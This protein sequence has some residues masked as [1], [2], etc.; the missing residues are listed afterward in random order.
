MD[1]LSILRA[2]LDPFATDAQ[3]DAHLVNA[4]DLP[5]GYSDPMTNSSALDAFTPKHA[6]FEA[7]HIR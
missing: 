3:S 2:K 7:L 6:S 5:M 4:L 1:R